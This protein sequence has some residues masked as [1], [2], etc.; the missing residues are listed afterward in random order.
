MLALA[1]TFPLLR[2]RFLAVFLAVFLA[3]FLAMLLA[4][5]LLGLVFAGLRIRGRLGFGRAAL[6]LASAGSM[7][8]T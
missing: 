6:E 1:A 3:I 7:L 5:F 4:M 2:A 8:A